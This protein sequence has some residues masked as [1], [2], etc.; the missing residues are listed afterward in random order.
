MRIKR[1]VHCM[2]FLPNVDIHLKLMARAAAF[3]NT[4]NSEFVCAGFD[5]HVKGFVTN[6]NGEV[7]LH[8]PMI[9]FAYRD[10]MAKADE[11]RDSAEIL[12]A[13]REYYKAHKT[14]IKFPYNEPTFGYVVKWLSELGKT[15][16]L[17]GLLA[18]ADTKL[19]PTWENGGLYYPRNN[20]ATDDEGRWT[21][22]D[23]FTGNAAIGYARLNVEDGMKKIYDDPWTAETLQSRPYI[24]GIDLSSGVDCLRGLWDPEQGAAIVTL[25]EWAGLG[26]GISFSVDNLPAGTWSVY[27]SQGGC[28][29]YELAKG[30]RIIVD[31]MVRAKEEVDFVVLLDKEVA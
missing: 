4:W 11:N 14:D 29:K 24:D 23:P 28:T 7:E 27:T 19:Q 31:A 16:E 5:S 3:M 6:I 12:K 2:V 1:W 17:D 10:A 30:G 22:M 20:K 13:A 21:H 9:A 18:Y 8:H 25:C 15:T 26:T